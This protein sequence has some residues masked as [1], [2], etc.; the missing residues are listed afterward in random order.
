M[1]K[2]LDGTEVF[3]EEKSMLDLT[4][5]YYTS[6]RE[7]P[8]FEERIKARLLEVIGSL[9]LISVSQKPMDF[10]EN[11]CV[12]DVGTSDD[13]IFRQ[14]QIGCEQAKTA[15]VGT[16]EADCLYP[17]GFYDFRPNDPNGCWRYNNLWI[18]NKGAKYYRKKEHS[19]C[20]QISGRE[21][22]LRAIE[23]RL[24]GRPQWN[25][26]GYKYY[27]PKYK[28]IIPNWYM[29][30]GYYPVVNIKTKEGMRWHTSHEHGV[31][32]VRIPYWGRVDKL[33]RK[34]FE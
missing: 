12:G 27:R 23:K 9:P 1:S 34:V 24:E 17:P 19:L 10:G 31:K 18:L 29:Y 6:N 25:P 22:L 33:E 28:G 14:I 7:K 8:E 30:S 21:H 13:N 20:A 32:T 15:L 5:I 16:A 3:L 4:V 26:K 11:I 2:A